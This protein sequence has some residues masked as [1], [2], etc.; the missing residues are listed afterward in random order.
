MGTPD[1]KF[2]SS[3]D[4]ITHEFTCIVPKSFKEKFEGMYEKHNGSTDMMII[5]DKIKE[6]NTSSGNLVADYEYEMIS[7]SDINVG[8]VFKHLFRTL[9]EPGRYMKCKVRAKD[10]KLMVKITDKIQTKIVIPVDYQKIPVS[11]AVADCTDIGVADTG[12]YTDTDG[13]KLSIR[14]ITCVGKSELPNFD[15]V[16]TFITEGLY[17]AFEEAES[18]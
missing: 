7:D 15:T 2:A 9:K 6:F 16:I 3:A 5:D 17:E 13:C 4:G 12:D 14:F 10:G 11:S 8:V 1:I 18:L